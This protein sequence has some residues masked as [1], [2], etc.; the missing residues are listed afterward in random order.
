MNRLTII[1]FTFLF[2][3]TAGPTRG[4]T[5]IGNIK[6][7]VESSQSND[8]KK[9]DY[10]SRR[11]KFLEKV[12][13]SAFKDFVVSIQDIEHR[14]ISTELL[15]A[16]VEQRNGTFVPHVLPIVAGTQVTWPNRDNIFHN[17]FSISEA[18]PFDLGYYKSRDDAK[19]VTFETPGRVNVFCSIHSQMNCIVLVMPNPWFSASDN[20]G[21]YE[22]KDIPAGTYKLKAWHERLPPKYF[23]VVIPKDGVVHLDI[24]M[25]LADLPKY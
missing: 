5:L 3:L 24:T 15:R 23:E 13:Y 9:S 1:T 17:V 2:L 16:T 19:V 4:G 7:Q 6:A 10:G 25:G 12:D 18:R 11:Y 8:G 20:R 21:F 14:P 22:I